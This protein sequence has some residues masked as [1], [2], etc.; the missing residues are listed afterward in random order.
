MNVSQQPKRR[1]QWLAE[2]CSDR[3]LA[4]TKLV[5]NAHVDLASHGD[6]QVSGDAEILPRWTASIEP[7]DA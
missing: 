1:W 7:N 2:D 4:A 5:V 6:W 3:G